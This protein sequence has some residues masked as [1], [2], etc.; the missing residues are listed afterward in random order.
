M[1]FDVVV[2]SRVRGHGH[3]AVNVPASGIRPS[4]VGGALSEAADDTWKHV[5][6]GGRHPVRWADFRAVDADGNVSG[7]VWFWCCRRA[8]VVSVVPSGEPPLSCLQSC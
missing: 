7:S 1:R 4:K 3:V 2:R 5:S 8:V 6:R